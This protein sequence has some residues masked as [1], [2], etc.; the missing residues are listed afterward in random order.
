MKTVFF[1]FNTSTIEPSQ[2]GRYVGK[3]FEVFTSQRRRMIPAPAF[4]RGK[5]LP[6]TRRRM[7][8]ATTV[9]I[10]GTGSSGARSASFCAQ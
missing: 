10:V 7:G 5:L 9:T 6:K 4:D 1:T 3:R 2:S 8:E